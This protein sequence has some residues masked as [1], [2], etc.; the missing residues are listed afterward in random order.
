MITVSKVF[1]I[2]RQGNL[3][4]SNEKQSLFHYVKTSVTT[5]A[6]DRVFRCMKKKTKMVSH[7]LKAINV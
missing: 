7:F 1:D 2:T 5:F 4:V 6:F 3:N